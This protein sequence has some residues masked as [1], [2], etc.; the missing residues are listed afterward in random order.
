MAKNF[1][2]F[3]TKKAAYITMCSQMDWWATHLTIPEV[4]EAVSGKPATQIDMTFRLTKHVVTSFSQ[5]SLSASADSGEY[6]FESVANLDQ[7]MLATSTSD[8]TLILSNYSDL[9]EIT[10]FQAHQSTI[11]RIETSKVHPN[12][13]FSAGDDKKVCGWDTRCFTRPSLFIT[14]SEEFHAVSVGVNG[15]LLA[16][17]TDATIRFYDIRFFNGSRTTE[18]Q[19]AHNLGKYSDVHSDM[20]TQLKF[21]P[22]RDHILTSAAEDGLIATYDTS[23]AAEEDA[24]QTILN[25]ECP[26][27]RFDYFGVDY[28]GIYSLST[29]ETLSFWHYP[30]AQRVGHFPRIREDLQA[31]YLVDCFSVPNTNDI[32]LLAGDHSG[33]AVVVQME[34]TSFKTMGYL[35][36]GHAASIRCCHA[37]FTSPV[38]PNGAGNLRI[39]TGGEDSRLCCWDTVP[40]SAASG[41]F[42]AAGNTM[43]SSVGHTGGQSA[44]P[45]KAK[46]DSSSKTRYKPY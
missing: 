20:I 39:V 41:A 24:I 17:S 21:H 8:N 45:M 5:H 6:V 9:S 15:T 29:V 18:H 43:G 3:A 2:S 25:T 1:G 34:P 31:D 12:L 14:N 46:K 42:A 10:R 36:G 13:L 27:G 22:T 35:E 11:N 30:S 44:G 38:G 23:T 26:V 4:Q 28:E 16:A 33:K 19:R 32:Y 40:S 37:A 7:T